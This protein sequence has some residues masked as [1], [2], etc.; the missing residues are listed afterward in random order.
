[1]NKRQKKKCKKKEEEKQMIAKKFA[2][3]LG[4]KIKE[5]IG[6]NYIFEDNNER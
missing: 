2:R 1:M 6:D 5:A 4:E 3:I